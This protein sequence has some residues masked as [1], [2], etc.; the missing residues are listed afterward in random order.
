MSQLVNANLTL[1]LYEELIDEF[2]KPSY[3]FKYDYGVIKLE[4]EEMY[5]CHIIIT[6]YISILDFKCRCIDYPLDSPDCFDLL[7][8]KIKELINHK[9]K[10]SED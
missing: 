1:M 9:L 3:I 2:S 10:Q 8:S 6:D 7:F 4:Y 5:I